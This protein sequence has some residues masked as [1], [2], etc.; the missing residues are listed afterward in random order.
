VEVTTI[1]DWLILYNYMD[2]L[3]I[4]FTNG[5]LSSKDV[6]RFFGISESTL[7]DWEKKGAIKSVDVNGLK[8]FSV[9]EVD[10][11]FRSM[12]KKGQVNKIFPDWFY[13]A[14]E[15]PVVGKKIDTWEKYLQ[16]FPYMKGAF[17]EVNSHK[18]SDDKL[19]N[20]DFDR[21]L[22][23][24]SPLAH[25][26]VRFKPKPNHPESKGQNCKVFPIEFEISFDTI[27]A[28]PVGENDRKCQMFTVDYIRISP[29]Y[30]RRCCAGFIG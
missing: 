6:C 19:E 1:F 20:Y 10:V 5:H 13:Y 16:E 23:A 24:N 28:T 8:K 27:Q 30:V 9:Q 25:H 15:D 21:I 22:R 11:M 26:K 3:T 2:N 18:L 29:H 7:R 17:E 14:Y 12:D 4:V